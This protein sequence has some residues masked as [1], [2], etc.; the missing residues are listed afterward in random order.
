[1]QTHHRCNDRRRGS[2]DC[3]THYMSSRTTN[4]LLVCNLRLQPHT[5]FLAARFS[6]RHLLQK[7]PVPRRS[8]FETHLDKI[9]NRPAVAI[10]VNIGKLVG[11]LCTREHEGREWDNRSHAPHY[12]LLEATVGFGQSSTL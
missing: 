4:Q 11:S 6:C 7:F 12:K 8:I 10:I 1:M 5:H 3:L 9:S 2:T